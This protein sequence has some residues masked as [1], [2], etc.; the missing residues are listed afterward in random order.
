MNINEHDYNEHE[1]DG[2]WLFDN[3]PWPAADNTCKIIVFQ[4]TL[5]HDLI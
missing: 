3:M 2:H 4:K 1:T 5:I